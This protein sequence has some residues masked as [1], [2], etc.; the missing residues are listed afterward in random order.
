MFGL[1]LEGGPMEG[2]RMKLISWIALTIALVP[3]A[4]YSGMVLVYGRMVFN[5]GN[6]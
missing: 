6:G 2:L 1:P 4:F 5:V 3:T